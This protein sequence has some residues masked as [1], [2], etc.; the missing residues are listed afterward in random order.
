MNMLFS[1]KEGL[2]A[3]SQCLLPL[4]NIEHVLTYITISAVK[5]SDFLLHSY[6]L[7]PKKANWKAFKGA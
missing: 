2:L 6:V 3:T 7:V 5:P 1:L 4:L